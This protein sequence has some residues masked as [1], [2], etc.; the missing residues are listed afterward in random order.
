M[1]EGSF[2]NF[3]LSKTCFDHKLNDWIVS[4]FTWYLTR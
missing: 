1:D 3:K 4:F 2:V